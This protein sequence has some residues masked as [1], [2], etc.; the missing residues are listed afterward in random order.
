MMQYAEAFDALGYKLISVRNDWTASK[1]GGVCVTIWKRELD[2]EE[3]SMDSRVR[4]GPISNWGHKAGNKRRIEHAALALRE[5][6]GWVDAILI[7]GKPGV[8][9]EDAQPWLPSQKGGRRWRV[10]FLDEE[11]GHIRLEAQ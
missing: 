10:V 1:P 3:M 4:G 2:W 7:S 8:S 9:Y 5:F 11:T 6:N